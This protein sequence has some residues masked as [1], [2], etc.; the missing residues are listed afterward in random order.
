MIRVDVEALRDELVARLREA[1]RAPANHGHTR[2]LARRRTELVAI[3]RRS[4]PR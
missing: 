2:T 1:S 3:Y 4:V